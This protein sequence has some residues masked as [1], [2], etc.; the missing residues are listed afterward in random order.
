[1]LWKG[2]GAADSIMAIAGLVIFGTANLWD[3]N[4]KIGMEATQAARGMAERMGLFGVTARARSTVA[5]DLCER[6]ED[7]ARATCHIAWGA[8]HWETYVAHPNSKVGCF[9]KLK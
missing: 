5:T 2:E 9:P 4:E 1:M 8:Y 7:W 3:T 6:S